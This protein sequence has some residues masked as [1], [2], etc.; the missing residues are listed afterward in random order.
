[1]Y[2]T[3]V[4]EMNISYSLFKKKASSYPETSNPNE[5]KITETIF[6]TKLYE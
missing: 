5:K 1:M 4:I 6:S 3:S 2:F